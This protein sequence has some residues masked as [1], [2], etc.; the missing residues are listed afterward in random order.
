M[1]ESSAIAIVGHAYRAPGVGRKGLWDFLAEAKCAFSR[2]PENRFDQDAF[3]DPDSQKQG[4][5]ATK[6]AHFL[7]G[8][9]YAFDAP[10]F[11][12]RPEE[13]RAVDPHHRLLLEC[14][15]EA[16]ESAGISLTDLAGGNI[17][18]FTA[19]S[20]SDFLEHALLDLP[21]STMWTAVGISGTMFANRLSYFFD[22]K[23]P[24]IALDAACASSTYA[25]HLACKS[26]L[27]GEC[28]AA[29]VGAASLLLGPEYWVTLDTMGALSVEGKSFSY[30]SKASGFGRGEGA[31]CFI[32][33]RLGDALE[34][35]DPIHSVIR[36]SACNHSGRSDG[37]TM[38]S[39]A[40]QIQLLRQVHEEIGL[41]PAET[42]VVEGHGTGTKVGDP[43]EAGAFAEALAQKRTPGN[44]LYIGSIKSNF[45]HLENASGA[46][47]M[48]KATLMLQHGYVLPTAHFEEMNPNI[49][50]KEKLMVAKTTLPWPKDAIKRVCITNFG[51]GGSNSALILDEAPKGTGSRH[52]LTNGVNGTSS[53]GM[54]NSICNG[55]GFQRHDRAKKLFV[56]SAKSEKSLASYLASFKEYLQTA[57]EDA[58]FAH[59]L[60]FTLGQRR[61]HHHWRTA[62][63]A[64]SASELQTQ[65]SGI[66][67]GKTKD[68]VISFVFTGQGAQHAQM[69]SELRQYHVFSN[70][71]DEAEYY[72][73]K[74]GATWSLTEEL[75]KQASESRVN[76][77]EISQPACTAVQIALLALL[78]SFAV[79]PSIVTGHSSG[80]IAAAYSAGMLSFETAMAVAF[81]RGRAAVELAQKSTHKGAMVALGVG[82]KDAMALVQD[83]TAGYAGIAAINSPQSVTV[84]G[85]ES[86][87]DNIF[88]KA[89][90]SGMFA[91]KLKVEVAYHSRHMEQ[92]AASYRASI[93]P[94]FTQAPD[95]CHKSGVRFISSV[96]GRAADSADASYWIDNLLKPVRFADS[97][98]QIFSSGEGD[99]AIAGSYK[100]PTIVVEIGPHSALRNPIKQ[101][102]SQ[103]SQRAD[104]KNMQFTYLPSLVRGT[105]ADETMLQ[106][107]GSLFSLGLPVDFTAI[108]RTNRKNAHVLTDLPAYSWDR[109]TRYV[110]EGRAVQKRL[111]PGLPYDPLIG[112]KNPSSEGNDASFRQV[113]T[114]DQMPWIRDHK[115]GG[116]VIMP[117]T[118]FMSM[119]IEAAR[120]LS[121]TVP[122]SIVVSEFYVKRSLVIGEDEHI[123]MTVKLQPVV[124][125]TDGISSSVWRFD[126]MSWRK[127][128]GWVDHCHGLVEA[129]EEDMD[130]ESR[131]MKTAVPLVH[132]HDMK[133]SS[134]FDEIYASGPREGTVYGPAFKSTIR[135]WEAP[136]WTV[137]ESK[138][139]ELDTARSCSP[140]GSP[141]SADPPTLDGFLQGFLP[142]QDAGRKCRALMPTYVGRLRVSN[143]IPVDH[144]KLRLFVVSRLMSHD[145]KTETLKITVAAFAQLPHSLLPIAEWESVTFR[146]ISS[147]H[148]SDALSRLPASFYHELLP[149]LDFASDADWPKFITAAPADE[150]G[151]RKR[152]QHE[153]VALEYMKRAVD[154]T[155]DLDYSDLPEHLCKFMSW[156]KRCVAREEHRLMKEPL[157]DL[158]RIAKADAGGELLCAVGEQMVPI[159]RGQ[160]QTLEIMLRDGLLARNYEQDTSNMRAA[161]TLAKCAR[162][163]SDINPEL[164]ILEIGGGTGSA[165]LPVLEELWGD[166]TGLAPFRDYT[167][168][169][170]SAGFF[171]NARVKLATWN[172]RIIY[173]KLDITQDP[174]T[175]GF[176]PGDYDLVIASNVL[177]ATADMTVTIGNVRS[178]LKPNGKILLLEATKHSPVT[179]PFSLLPGWWYAVDEYRNLEEG[180][181]LSD[182]GWR[183]LLHAQGFSGVDVCIK[184]YEDPCSHL[185]SVMCTTKVG[186]PETCN[187]SLRSITV[188][189]LFMDEEEL[190]F[191]QLV[192]S[193][194]FEATGRHCKIQTFLD[195]DAE[196]D[197][198]CIFIDSPAN[199]LLAD[200]SQETFEMLQNILLETRGLLWVVLENAGPESLSIQ[201]IMQCLRL[202]M[203][204]KNLMCFKNAPRSLVGADAIAKLARRLQDAELAAS[205][206]HDFVWQ[207]GMIKVPR[208]RQSVEAKEVFGAETGVYV[209]KKQN[210][211]EDKASFEIT[212]DTAG[213]PESLYFRRTDALVRP[214]GDGEVLVKVEAA[215]L[216]SRDLQLVLGAVP[217]APPGL[218]GVG[219]V[220][221]VGSGVSSLG[222]GD[223]VYYGLH[224]GCLATHVRMPAWQANKV[225]D[226]WS[227]A[228][229]ASISIA[230]QVA[231]L[232][233]C[234]HARLRKGETVLVHA[235]SGAV[236]QACIVLA[237]HMGARVF[238]TAGTREK[239]VLLRDTY[240]IPESCLFSSRTAEFRNGILCETDG[241]GV[242]VVVNSLSG[243]LLQQTWAL[244]ADLGRFVELGAKDSRMNSSLAMRP[245]DRNVSFSGID[246]CAYAEK[247]PDEV[248]QMVAELHGMLRRGVIKPI[249]SVAT[250][251]VSDLAAALRKLQSGQHMGKIVIS[252]GRH[253]EVVAECHPELGPTHGT[254]LRPDATYVITG[255]TGGIG[256]FLAPWMVEHGARN[257]VLLG[258][259][260]DTRPEVR[261]V[262][263]RY[264]DTD[265]EIRAIACHVAYR[266]QLEA[267]LDSITDLPPVRGVVHGALF[268]KDAM[269]MN[270]TYQDWQNITGP[271]V[272]A[273]WHLDEMLPNLDFFI[274]LSS[275]L[276]S[277]GNVG[278]A[279][280]AGTA[281][282]FDGFVDYRRTRGLPATS[283]ALP[284]V[285]DVGYVAD[286]NRT[287]EL[288]ESLGAC[289]S[290]PHLEVLMR[291]AI[292]GSSSGLNFQGKAM[293]FH[294]ETGAGTDGMA[295]QCYNV[296]DFRR[297][298]RTEQAGQAAGC[299]TQGK[300]RS[301][302]LG[303]AG[304]EGYSENLLGA[305]MDKVSSITM[306]DR[307]EVEADAPLANYSLDSLVSVE[308]RNWIRRET[309]V[310]L[311]LAKLVRSA[312]LRAV[313]AYIVPGAKTGA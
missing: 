110:N 178:L 7:P 16:A 70:A 260:G 272:Q 295:W 43:I 163:L 222:P 264:K 171:E 256:L 251:P 168:T 61:T 97:I 86:A 155:S 210:I 55:E 37:I 179:L 120:K 44:P 18:V 238:A 253:D 29:V 184:D 58:A 54:S 57:P 30:D 312:N 152:V 244:M 208:L 4:C 160:V 14:T 293:S 124:T 313:A 239:R 240:G 64:I 47:A 49:Q 289:L 221:K 141:F 78:K 258:R 303:D 302:G 53:N 96:T 125:G 294:L 139:R 185:M 159:L 109:S 71:M 107:A 149:A 126:I 48:T 220:S 292:I 205:S 23:G 158:S 181:L 268:L 20:S 228:D 211:W 138:L 243:S 131:T 241:K 203:E 288:K 212:M 84:S 108:N 229:A 91:R 60:S 42:A 206:D 180:P 150:D 111:H 6:G 19:M 250:V 134:L 93:E 166:A 286:R 2:V 236:G 275:M 102:L 88:K 213:A 207:D 85:D 233:L 99:T 308:L 45:G 176:A 162:H 82:Y 214:L 3:H 132:S 301:Q 283:I 13:A 79:E 9:V 254:L 165:T 298:A 225:P 118:G 167:F 282:F 246:L 133:E 278:Q 112:W 204:P 92:V 190:D 290:R 11:N 218:E 1:D 305:L 164:R 177:H 130:V 245:F 249:R 252:M 186:K 116:E 215:G 307:D 271:R 146:S 230:Y 224:G 105:G 65:L 276:G 114:L 63:V 39:G 129:Q 311:P 135:Y 100:T 267:A 69:A 56:L 195:I 137:M 73:R 306:I 40:A 122:G 66:K 21:T 310:D 106:L 115:V 226:G 189:G 31:A 8:D 299:D 192:A 145:V 174:A 32:L 77:A 72:L 234:H 95:S 10:F 38:P 266:E 255:G 154:G 28:T 201:G 76:D 191:A 81:F 12:L 196:D 247:R 5:F 17:G 27:R 197:D 183:R 101:T 281:T 274:M 219:V 248:R 24:S 199:S 209:R 187:G 284:V 265:V 153:R 217:W 68:Q 262:L 279:I 227:N 113:F 87:I 270:A 285:L 117:M 232:A 144:D 121:P 297:I 75:D 156:A 89:E 231:Y 175:Q 80:E 304:S 128:D 172:Q 50:G 103:L 296:R 269:F 67:L 143:H 169:D 104:S 35:G 193:Q 147:A 194:V 62:A 140:S 123:D 52:K 34:A 142:L 237:Q 280:Y 74:L 15:F 90:G 51:F 223:R 259:S 200:L 119:A 170:I 59:D 300:R 22:L 263:Q 277:C 25:T 202:E 46:I 94:F 257:I 148:A 33:K 41:D 216:S 188:C 273:A 26:L 127:E 182:D 173:K 261:K 287:E 291:G 235:A 161:V 36:N 198:L 157:P 151:L 98:S 83:N 242:D 136:G 309:G